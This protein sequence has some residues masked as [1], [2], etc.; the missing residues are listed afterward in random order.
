MVGIDAPEVRGEERPQGLVTTAYLKDRVDD[1]PL[2][3][4][5]NG[6]EGKYGRVLGSILLAE[7]DKLIDLNKELIAKGLAQEYK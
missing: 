2:F 4:R 5:S 6:E 1:G 3:L 7:G